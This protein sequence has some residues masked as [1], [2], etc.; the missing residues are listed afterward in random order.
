MYCMWVSGVRCVA[1]LLCRRVYDARRG[2]ISTLAARA[3]FRAWLP[4]HRRRGGCTCQLPQHAVCLGWVAQPVDDQMRLF[5]LGEQC[6]DL[7]AA[8]APGAP[9]PADR[10]AWL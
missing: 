5:V 4:Q 8:P 7:I 1:A 6:L 10:V 3:A 9:G 2:V